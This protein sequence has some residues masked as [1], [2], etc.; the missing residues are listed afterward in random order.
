MGGLG[1][2]SVPRMKGTLQPEAL[3]SLWS[4]RR[5]AG[6]AGGRQPQVR[7][8]DHAT[9]ST[10]PASLHGGPPE[11]LR[12]LTEMHLPQTVAAVPSKEGFVEEV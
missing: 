2:G 5:E 9:N 6:G 4:S 11:P 7:E 8:G 10:Q 12:A 3:V 1:P